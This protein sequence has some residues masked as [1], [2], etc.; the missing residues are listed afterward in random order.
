MRFYHLLV[1]ALVAAS[2]AGVSTPAEPPV[3]ATG[4]PAWT[5]WSS[6]RPETPVDLET[7]LQW[8]LSRNPDLVA[9]RQNADVSAVAMAVARLFPMSV[10]PS[11]TVALRPWAFERDIGQGSQRLGT[12]VAVAW[13]QPLELGRRGPRL[14]QAQAAYDQTQWNI[15]QA[16]LVTLVQTYRF[17]Q[18]A[19]YRREKF[20]VARQLA[21]FNAQLLLTVRR[22]VAAG[23]ATPTDLVLAEVENQSMVQ[24]LRTAQQDYLDAVTDLRKQ[25]GLPE[26]AGSAVPVGAL[27]IPAG[28]L[29]SDEDDLIRQALESHPDINVALAQANNSQAAVSLARADRIPIASVGPVYERDEVGTTFY[30]LVVN[31]PV[32]VLNSGRRLVW[33]REQE[34]NR[35]LVAAEQVRVRTIVRVKASLAKWLQVKDLV[36]EVEASTAAIEVQTQKLERIYTAGQA[37]L[38]K[39]L[40]VRQRLIEAE[41]ARLDIVWQATQAYADLLTATGATPLLGALPATAE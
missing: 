26:H 40:Q 31:T 1:A 11:V 7:A 32:P 35:D 21:D 14:V 16:E 36:A 2:V 19:T 39:L 27:Q 28:A 10:N 15:L 18:T 41:N 30:G 6:A 3:H 34:Y 4:Q 5:A 17:H 38:L 9:V 37:D 23:L 22:Q 25:M 8:T 13:T 33:Q 24:R 12:S 20:R 29:S